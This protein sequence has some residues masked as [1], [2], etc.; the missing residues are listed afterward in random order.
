[1]QLFT[2]LKLLNESPDKD[3]CLVLP[4]GRAIRADFHVTEVGHVTK[5]FVDCGGDKHFQEACVLQV[6]LAANDPDHRLRSGKLASIL[7][8]AGPLMPS[9][10]L[11]V[12]FEYE[13]SLISQ[14]TVAGFETR[15]EAIVFQ[16]RG[17][18][19]DC[20]AKEACGLEPSS[21]GTEGCC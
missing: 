14:Y 19:T 20:L 10:D 18:H 9:D 13:D 12:E 3:L 17:K 2:L 11:A 8:L 21:C 16:L 6:W 4:D 1:M 7:A 15:P 5:R